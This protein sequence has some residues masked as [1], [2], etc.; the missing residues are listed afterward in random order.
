MNHHMGILQVDLYVIGRR[1][2]LGSKVGDGEAN[3]PRPLPKTV[4]GLPLK[5]RFAV[6]LYIKGVFRRDT[7]LGP[8][9]GS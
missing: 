4:E 1:A 3:H 8:M 9:E 2:E 6:F 7:L 5:T